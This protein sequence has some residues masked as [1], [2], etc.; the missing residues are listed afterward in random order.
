MAVPF[1]GAQPALAAPDDVATVT[2]SVGADRLVTVNWALTAGDDTAFAPQVRIDITGPGGA[3]V[4]GTAKGTCK[5]DPTLITVDETGAGSCTFTAGAA[6]GDYKV[7]ATPVDG[8]GPG[9]ASEEATV[10]LQRPVGKVTKLK[11]T[12]TGANVAV[13]WDDAGVDWKTGD[14]R[15][16]TVAITPADKVGESDCDEVTDASEDCTFTAQA[17]A[18]TTYTIT[19]TAKTDEG[20]SNT[21]ASTTVNVTAPISAP[22]GGVSD[23]QLTSEGGKVV[24]SWDPSGV[25]SWGNGEHAGFAVSVDPGTVDG[26]TCDTSSALLAKTSTG[27]T[28]TP[29]ATGTYTVTVTPTNDVDDGTGESESIIVEEL[30]P[31]GTFNDSVNAEADGADVT[32]TWDP[33][34]IDWG[35]AEPEARFFDVTIDKATIAS[36][37]TCEGGIAAEDNDSPS[38]TFTATAAGPYKVTV[39]ARNDVGSGVSDSFDVTVDGTVPTSNPQQLALQAVVDS[40][41][42]AQVNVT[43]KKAGVTSWGLAKDPGFKVTVAGTGIGDND[44][45]VD[46]TGAS[47]EVLPSTAE[48]CS[49]SATAAGQ[50]TVTLTPTNDEGDSVGTAS[51]IAVV[52]EEAPVATITPTASEPSENG[53]ITIT[54]DS[55]DIV[56]GTG[57][58]RTIDVVANPPGV[59][60]GVS[61]A[62]EKCGADM[63]EDTESCWFVPTQGGKY[64]VS[65]TPK[66][67]MGRGMAVTKEIEVEATA[68]SGA[69]TVEEPTVSGSTVTVNWDTA[70]VNWGTGVNRVLKVEV[71][72]DTVGASTCAATL[73]SS[74]TGCQFTAL[75]AGTYTITVTPSTSEGDAEATE[76]VA[77]VSTLAP[78][79][80][81]DVEVTAGQSELMVSWAAGEDNG[82]E[83]TYYT[84]TATPGDATCSTA[85]ADSTTCTITGLTPGTPYSVT[86]VAHGATGTNSEPSE[87]KAGTPM[88]VN[89]TGSTVRNASGQLQVFAR[90]GN[91]SVVTS[92]QD[93]NG[94]WGAWTSLGGG[95]V[96]EPLVF[97]G[98]NGQLH[99]LA[100]GLNRAVWQRQQTSASGNTWSSWTSAGGDVRSIA[101]EVQKSGVAVVASRAGDGSVWTISQSAAGGTTW[102][103]WQ[104]LGGSVVNDPRLLTNSDGD[105]EVIAV[106]FDNALWHRVY[107]GTTWS[108][109]ARVSSA[110]SAIA[111]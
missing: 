61:A 77:E 29:T 97:R 2:A 73:V 53:V 95:I 9:A 33:S 74:A 19:V 111:A 17:T 38:C 86:V 6:D 44:C 96:G 64:T 81:T 72:P 76:V 63:P 92:V 20:S 27:C 100:I 108:Q 68:P 70:S 85:D 30:G 79:A 32:V 62:G 99:L 28:F 49:F 21:S 110:S 59:S 43:W 90:A 87:I 98:A 101:V 34:A 18:A 5:G 69:V 3:P 71:S 75:E 40:E 89:V 35:T 107:D 13:T 106:G 58:D 91:G 48:A 80:P 52:E 82:I 104:A 84:A 78:S 65:W 4:T 31:Q 11:A 105:L 54:W 24:A 8:G 55:D 51:D 57:D 39:T 60:A 102:T 109:W 67:E 12:A 41:A 103:S 83:V 14:N 16:F 26:N 22:T 94:D 46:E 37:S 66:T 23:L 45:G 42:L 56:W 7:K 36:G 50:Y 15:D 25:T 93:E 88:G 1:I 10:S 47:E